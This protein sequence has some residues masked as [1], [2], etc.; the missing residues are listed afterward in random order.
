MTSTRL[1]FQ[2]VLGVLV[3]MLTGCTVGGATATGAPSTA[4]VSPTPLPSMTTT[5]P[6]DEAALH[7]EEALRNYFRAQTQC[8]ADPPHT[9]ITCFDGVA[10]G[11]ELDNMRNTLV[12]AQAMAQKSSGDVTVVSV[13]RVGVDLTDKVTEQPPTVPKVVFSVCVDVSQV[14]IVDKDGKS[15]VPPDRK[16]RV[17]ASITV[18]DYKYPDP[19]QWRVGYVVESKD[20]TC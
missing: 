1:T 19:S 4:A 2:A 9:P 6:E 15:V 7:A 3:L 16:P 13:D 18:Y 5:S 8:M 11:G 14:N 10:I 17:R 12:S 20:S